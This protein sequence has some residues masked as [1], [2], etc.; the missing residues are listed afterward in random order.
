M[1][2]EGL[3]VA[4]P[5]TPRP[6]RRPKRPRES[7]LAYRMELLEADSQCHFERAHDL[8]GAVGMVRLDQ[9]T[10]RRDLLGDPT[11]GL[12]GILGDIRDEVHGLVTTVGELQ[13]AGPSRRRRLTW[14][15]WVPLLIAV[16]AG[17][18]GGLVGAF[19]GLHP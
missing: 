1:L 7:D 10:L 18:V 12:K 11:I 17:A 2:R 19:S 16:V 6:H 5:L 13:Q 14:Q 3:P 9:E 4:I 15:L 8:N